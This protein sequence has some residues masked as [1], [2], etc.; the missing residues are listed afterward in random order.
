MNRFDVTDIGEQHDLTHLITGKE[1]K[2]VKERKRKAVK[3]QEKQPFYTVQQLKTKAAEINRQ[4][5]IQNSKTK[6]K[7]LEL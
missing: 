3:L 5:K 7:N 2:K 4:P 6:S 1:K